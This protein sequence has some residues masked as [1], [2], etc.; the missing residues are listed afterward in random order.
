MDDQG[1]GWLWALVDV[2]FVAV[3]AAALA[4]GIMAWR[5]RS[6]SRA[7]EDVRDRATLRNYDQ[8]PPGSARGG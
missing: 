1:G 7:V 2:V 3:L 5:R 4:Y 8:K 6:K